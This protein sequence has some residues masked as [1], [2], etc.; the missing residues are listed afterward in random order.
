MNQF[1]FLL[2]ILLYAW[3][4]LLRPG[5][6][7]KGIWLLFHFTDNSTHL[8]QTISRQ[9][10][11]VVVWVILFYRSHNFYWP[12]YAITFID[13]Y[14]VGRRFTDNNASLTQEKNRFIFYDFIKANLSTKTKPR[15]MKGKLEGGLGLIKI[16]FSDPHLLLRSAVAAPPTA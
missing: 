12:I 13:Q 2:L 4:I 6:K 9:F 5:Q 15:R 8:G 16:L 10:V 7:K 11:W 3:P 14:N 1:D